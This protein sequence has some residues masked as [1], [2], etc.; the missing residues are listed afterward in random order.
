[1]VDLEG[2]HSTPVGYLAYKLSHAC[3]LHWTL[4]EPVAEQVAETNSNFKLFI[5]SENLMVSH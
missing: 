5:L 2:E 1:M 3:Y 4:V